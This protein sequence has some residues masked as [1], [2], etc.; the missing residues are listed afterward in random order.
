MATMT[1]ISQHRNSGESEKR[2]T[3]LVTPAGQGAAQ[4]ITTPCPWN[5]MNVIPATASIDL[6][7]DAVGVQT[8]TVTG[9][10][11]VVETDNLFGGIVDQDGFTLTVNCCW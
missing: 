11:G 1:L 9:T 2:D 6:D 4:K 7:P 5:V 10:S 8:I 3:M